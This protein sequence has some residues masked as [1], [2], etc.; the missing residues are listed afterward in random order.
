MTISTILLAILNRIIVGL[1][2]AVAVDARKALGVP[3]LVEGRHQGAHNVLATGNAGPLDRW[4]RVLVVEMMTVVL[5]V[6]LGLQIRAALG[7]RGRWGP[8]LH[9]LGRHDG[10]AH[11][12]GRGP[13]VHGGR[14]GAV[15]DLCLACRERTA[16]RR[17]WNHGKVAVGE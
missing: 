11:R 4:G 5:A 2:N 9:K 8:C 16:C 1:K 14:G 13:R 17:W 6:V 7:V 3:H 12:G 10:S 15:P